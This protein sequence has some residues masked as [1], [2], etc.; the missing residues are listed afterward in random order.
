MS[1]TEPFKD[2]F[3]F[4]GMIAA[5]AI[6]SIDGEDEPLCT[7]VAEMT[8]EGAANMDRVE[9]NTIAESVAWAENWLQRTDH[10]APARLLI[11][12][13][14]APIEDDPSAD[15]A[16]ALILHLH[17]FDPPEPPMII[18]IAYG[19]GDD[20]EIHIIREGFHLAD[21]QDLPQDL[22][23]SFFGGISRHEDAAPI[24]DRPQ[25]DH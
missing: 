15:R 3:E 20:A 1:N 24:W 11:Y 7:I 5:H 16:E 21:Q 2:R 10:D 22:V 8:P 4:A 18:T 9:R 12:D 14:Y 25:P 13:G 6:W 17:S 23:D 19:R